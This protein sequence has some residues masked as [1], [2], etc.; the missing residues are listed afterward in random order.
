MLGPGRLEAI[1]VRVTN[2]ERAR[3][4]Y[5][6]G[7]VA[8]GMIVPAMLRDIATWHVARV[9]S[10]KDFSDCVIVRLVPR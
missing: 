10:P 3:G 1:E 8:S 6:R 9:R 2:T 4:G 5:E 7:D